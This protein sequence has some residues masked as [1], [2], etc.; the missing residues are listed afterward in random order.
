V[1]LAKG[2]IRAGIEILKAERGVG[3]D[4]VDAV[5]LA[6][7]FGNFIRRRNAL[8]IGLLP[9]IEHERIHFIG[10]AALV[11]A[12]MVLACADYREE[13]EL[14][15]RRTEYLELGGRPDFQTQFATAMMFP[16]SE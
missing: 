3:D 1:Q 12:K 16:E 2:A 13:A 6:G 15:S 14:I 11:G 5:L 7:G 4:G 9:P 8:R 10:N